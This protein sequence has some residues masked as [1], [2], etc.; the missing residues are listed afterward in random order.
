MNATQRTARC[1]VC[2]RDVFPSL[3]ILH[4]A[5]CDACERELIESRPP[6][7]AYDL[8]VERF[9]AFWHGIAEAAAARDADE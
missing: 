1:L 3:S 5:L 4:A 8:F 9:R 2:D 7:P 6:D